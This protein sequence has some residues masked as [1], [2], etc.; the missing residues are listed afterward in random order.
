[1]LGEGED[2]DRDTDGKILEL[3][4]SIDVRLLLVMAP[5]TA[6]R[7]QAAAKIDKAKQKKAQTAILEIG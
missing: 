7:S 1:M 3:P 6:P 5:G 2:P 4:V